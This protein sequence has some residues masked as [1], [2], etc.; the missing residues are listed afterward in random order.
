MGVGSDDLVECVAAPLG[1]SPTGV[2]P[3]VRPAESALRKEL[4][5]YACSP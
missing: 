2:G 4:N 1:G 3:T 5:R